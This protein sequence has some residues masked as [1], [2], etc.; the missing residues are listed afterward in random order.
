MMSL[1]TCASTTRGY[2][3]LPHHCIEEVLIIRTCGPIRIARI[4]YP[5]G[6]LSLCGGQHGSKRRE[7]SHRH[8]KLTHCCLPFCFL[9]IRS[10]LDARPT[11]CQFY[12]DAS[13]SSNLKMVNSKFSLFK[14]SGAVEVENLSTEPPAGFAGQNMFGWHTCAIFFAMN[15]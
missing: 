12:R 13:W 4:G 14:I 6:I 7:S 15:P 10:E 5:V 2:P 1:N 9:V 11:K 8:N 3:V